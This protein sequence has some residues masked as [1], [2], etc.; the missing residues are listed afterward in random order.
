MSF[1]GSVF[2]VVIFLVIIVA[3]AYGGYVYGQMVLQESLFEVKIPINQTF[4]F[5]IN[6]L[7]DI[8][9]R[10]AIVFPVSDS[11][12]INES[13]PI[14]TFFVLDEVIKVPVSLPTGEIIVDVPIKKTISINTTIN[15][16]KKMDINKNISLDIDK[17]FSFVINKDILIPIDTEITTKVPVPEWIKKD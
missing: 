15:V 17:S 13:V 6:Q 14:N 3:V 1:I 12:I 2:K 4:S 9:I 7:V 11:F 5:E 10:T 16:Y 8:P